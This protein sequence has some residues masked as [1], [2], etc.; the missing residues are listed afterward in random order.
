MNAFSTRSPSHVIR[1]RFSSP[2]FK[3]AIKNFKTHLGAGVKFQLVCFWGDSPQWGMA[4][5]FMRFLDHTQRRTTVGR[6]PLDEWSARRRDL[7]LTTLTT[8]IHAPGGIR[9]HNLKRRAAEDLRLRSSGYWDREI[10]ASISHN[11]SNI[12]RPKFINKEA[13]SILISLLPLIKPYVLRALL[14]IARC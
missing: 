5:S 7:Y 13:V 12:F 14:F 9:T 2:Q 10:S 4:S 8:D 11:Y 6:T 1:L 3:C